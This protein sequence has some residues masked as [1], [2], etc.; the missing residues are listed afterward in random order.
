MWRNLM[1]ASLLGIRPQ[2]TYV[3]PLEMYLLNCIRL[4]TRVFL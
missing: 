3:L 1:V 2:P 4:G